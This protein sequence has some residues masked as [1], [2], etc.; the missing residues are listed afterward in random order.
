MQPS[1]VDA[2]C[3]TTAQGAIVFDR[4]RLPQVDDAWFAPNDSAD[5]SRGGRGAV[6]RVDTPAGPAVL[7]HYRRGGVMARFSRDRYLWSGAARTRSFREFDLLRQLAERGLPVAPPLAARYLRCDLLRYT[8]DLLTLEI[9]TAQT[10]AE[11]LPAVLSNGTALDALGETLA[12]FHLNGACHADLNAHNIMLD[13]GGQWWLIDFDRGRLRVPAPGW[14]AS[15]LARLQRSWRKLGA[16]SQPS[17]L[18]AWQRLSNA[19]QAALGRGT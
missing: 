4:R 17:G 9:P 19:H 1:A 5:H 2:Q 11:L 7:R 18:A 14:W 16:F 15:R 12:R 10:L 8:A 13:Q 6:W 3:V